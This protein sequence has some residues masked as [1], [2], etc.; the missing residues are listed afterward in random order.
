[1][2]ERKLMEI[3]LNL[4]GGGKATLS[5][6]LDLIMMHSDFISAQWQPDSIGIE[7][8]A[9]D[10]T[11]KVAF[12]PYSKDVKHFVNNYQSW[13]FDIA[14]KDELLDFFKKL[15]YPCTQRPVI[16]GEE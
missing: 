7:V 14:H 1:M 16:G 9:Y 12:H 13:Y 2:T 8:M 4:H 5:Y 11:V 6:T 3:E 15:G 10:D